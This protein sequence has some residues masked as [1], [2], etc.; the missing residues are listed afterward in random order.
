M[1]RISQS[2]P[3]SDR[4]DGSLRR[5]RRPSIASSDRVVAPVGVATLASAFAQSLP[6][7]DTVPTAYSHEFHAELLY[8]LCAALV[9]EG[10]GSAENWRKCEES[11]VVFAQRAIMESIG[12]ERWNLLQRNVEYHVSVSDVAEQSGEDAVSAMANWL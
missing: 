2:R 10:L 6:T 9:R 12:Q 3:L 4:S 11:A 1:Q 7:L 5:K 8:H